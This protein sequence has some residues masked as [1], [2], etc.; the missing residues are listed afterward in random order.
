MYLLNEEHVGAVTEAAETAI[1]RGGDLLRWWNQAQP[2]LIPIRHSFR[3]VTMQAFFE[4]IPV[5]GVA[6]LGMGCLQTSTFRRGPGVES[7]EPTVL[8]SWI[9]QNAVRE[10]YRPNRGGFLY[11]PLLARGAGPEGEVQRLP[12][13]PA[14]SLTELCGKYNW[15]V[16]RLDLPDYAYALPFSR[17]LTRLMRPFLKE[18]GSVV[19]HRSFC[20]SLRPPVRGAREQVTFGYAVVPWRIDPTILGFGPGRFYAAFKQYR[21]CL[22]EDDS[23]LVEIV[24]VVC[25]RSEKILDIGGLDPVYGTVGLLDALTLRRGS[26][27]QGAHKA[28]D[29]YAMGHHGRVHVNMLEGMREIWEGTNWITQGVALG[30][31]RA[32]GK[33]A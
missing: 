9:M 12:Q 31:N 26:M 10:C 5:E 20:E 17:A 8:R 21:V 19:F 14:V 32:E 3:D 24:F 1:R 18:S 28:I 11:Q 6:K 29:Q 16:Q 13:G 15:V 22:M 30:R 23:I 2:G 7:R 25:P 33:D 4:T 27:L